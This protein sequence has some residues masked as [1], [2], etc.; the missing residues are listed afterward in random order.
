MKKPTM[1][2]L[3]FVMTVS[4]GSSYAQEG[5]ERRPPKWGEIPQEHLTMD[6]YA[7]DSSAAVVILADYGNVFF[8]DDLDMVFERHTRIK[9]LTEAGYEWG[10]VTVRYRAEDRAQRVKD[11]EGRTYY[12]AEGGRVD[13][14]EMDK[15]SVFDEDVDGV[16]RRVRFTL[17][18]LQPGSVIEYRYKVV[19]TDPIYF[20]DW[21]FQ[22]SEPVL[23]SEYRAEIPEILPTTPAASV[24]YGSMSTSTCPT[25]RLS[26]P[27]FPR[28]MPAPCRSHCP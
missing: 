15:G 16:W 11:I 1:L 20:P 14:R 2:F 24:N 17:P 5:L 22:K 27:T 25:L 19:S 23:W 4:A 26:A 7:P 8:E 12:A 28:S 18:A 3:S 9:I 21:A 6:H 13:T 10:N